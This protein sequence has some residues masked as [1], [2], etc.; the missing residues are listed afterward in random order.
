MTPRRCFLALVAAS[1]LGCAAAGLPDKPLPKDYSLPM[2]NFPMA[3]GLRVVVQEDHSA[4]TVVVASFYGVG[5]SSDPK[6]VEGLAHFVEHLAFRTRPG[7]IQLW[8]HLKRTGAF[9]NASTAWDRTEYHSLAH[10]DQLNDLLQLEAWRL[11]RTL[12]GVTPEVFATEREVVRNEKRLSGETAGSRNFDL[13]AEALFPKGHPLS[14]S[15]VG[16]HESLSAAT[17]DHAKAFVKEHYR[18]DNCVIVVRGDVSAD[19]VGKLLGMWPP[20]VLFGPGGQKGPPVPPR[21][22]LANQ[23]SPPVPPPVNTKLVRERAPV[24]QPELWLGWSAPAG[25]RGNDSLLLFMGDRLNSALFDVIDFEDDE[26]DIESVGGGA[27]PLNDGSIVFVRAAL[28]PGADPERARKRVLDALVNSWTNEGAAFETEI[29]RWFTAT[30]ILLDVSNPLGTATGLAEHVATTGR[31]TYFQDQFEELAKVKPGQV[32]DLAYKYLRRERSVA[33]LIEP[34]S[35]QVAR[36]G[37]TSSTGGRSSSEGPAHDIGR[38]SATTSVDLSPQKIIQIARAPSLASLPRWTLP[39]GLKVVATR[40]GTA[41]IAQVLVGIRGGDAHTKPVGL[42]SYARGFAERRCNE[43]GSLA[44]VGGRIGDSMGTL[45][46]TFSV[47]VISGNLENGMAVL[48]DTLACFELREERF[49]MHDRMLDRRQKSFNRVSKMP[50]FTANKRLWEALYPDH[51]YG[52]VAIDP[53]VLRT[54]RQED[55]AGYIR[56]HYRPGN[57]VAVVVGDVDPNQ[58]KTMADKYLTRWSGGGGSS[59]SM[60]PAPP[61]PKERRGILIDRPQATQATIRVACRLAEATPER[62]PAY[63]LLQKLGD[64]RAWAVR[65]EWGAT[66][67]LQVGVRTMPGGA[68]HFTISGAIENAQVTRSLTRLLDTVAELGSGRLDEKAFGLARW[69][70]AREFSRRFVTGDQIASAIIQAAAQDWPDDVFDKY[71]ERLA[72]MTPQ[73]VAEIMKPCVGHEIISVVGQAATLRAQLTGTGLK[74]D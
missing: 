65:E 63:E 24:A 48:S 31:T 23:P 19:E 14:R 4:P 38:G 52:T 45:N 6:G 22:P 26:D 17:L 42:A 15:V 32:M 25:H 67:G 68:A 1:T 20:E 7:G 54:I 13:L 46:S 74:L 9:F 44:A 51:P 73:V 29:N 28:K 41:P 69:D 36:M 5:S 2:K 53:A 49:L 37:G 10:K 60:P 11:S 64:E 21:A 30:G 47:D 57:A 70:L 12:E 66:Y 40:Y 56:S 61:P 3:S 43:Y 50:D 62:L 55:I 16:S 33:V 39:N 72:A 18:P 59:V 71:P 35:D 27:L 34:E 8:D 58:V